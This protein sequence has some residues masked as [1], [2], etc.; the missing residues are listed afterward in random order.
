MQRLLKNKLL[1]SAI[2]LTAFVLFLVSYAIKNWQDFLSLRLEQP[3]LLLLVGAGGLA[4]LYS[5]GALMDVVLRPMGLRLQR[6]ETFGLAIITRL[7]N[8]VAPGRLGLAIRASYLKRKYNFALSK[9]VSALGAAHILMYLFSSLLGLGSLLTLTRFNTSLDSATFIVLLSGFS[10]FL[11]GLLLFSPKVK[12]GASFF[13]RHVS[14][15]VNGWLLIRRDQHILQLASM[16]ALVHVLIMV[17]VLFASFNTL[18][19]GISLLQASFIT[20]IVILGALIGITPAGLGV[21]EGLIV[22]A[23]AVL[24]I[25]APVALAAALVRR[26]VSFIILLVVAPLF[27]RKLFDLSFREVLHRQQSQSSLQSSQE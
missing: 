17:V 18:G 15:V 27:S 3:Y 9:F 19:A 14:R 26:A 23:A 11:L 25:P 4:S 2:I 24:G 6:T 12:E 8:Q 20:S 16:W 21:S 22:V 5:N 7:S 13:T 1:W 10:I